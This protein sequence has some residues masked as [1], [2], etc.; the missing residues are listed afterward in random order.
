MNMFKIITI[1]ISFSALI[2]SICTAY[3][4]LFSRFQVEIF[5]KP[6]II[7]TRCN[8]QL[9][10]IISCEIMNKGAKSGIINDI[11][12]LVQNKQSNTV[13]KTLL[14]PKYIT[15]KYNLLKKTKA[16]FEYFQSVA[17]SG[18]NHISRFII[19]CPSEDPNFANGEFVFSLYNQSPNN[20]HKWCEAKN[21]ILLKIDQTTIDDW[22]NKDEELQLDGAET[23]NYRTE[24]A[25]KL[26]G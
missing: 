9:S 3:F 23:I 4:T 7:L 24:L 20:G 14:L 13:N 12:L 10:I 21:Q 11:V 1:F 2:V 19:F 6:F 26:I 22:K 5:L 18:K 15:K 25:E 16:N 8:G 17:V